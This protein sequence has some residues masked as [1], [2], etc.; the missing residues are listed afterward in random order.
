MHLSQQK[1]AEK[2]TVDCSPN[3]LRPS[4]SI[5]ILHHVHLHHGPTGRGEA[6]RVRMTA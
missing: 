1:F 6:A 3:T 4:M 2:L 5:R